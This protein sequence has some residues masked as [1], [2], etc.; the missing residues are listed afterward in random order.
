MQTQ[1]FLHFFLRDLDKLVAEIEA[2]PTEESL[3]LIGGD[4]KNAAGTL[5]LHLAGNLQHFFGAILGGTGYE[6]QRDLEF[7]ARNVPKQEILAGL[8]TARKVVEQVLGNMTDA[9]LND[10]FPSAHFGENR[11]TLHALLHLL[12][13]LSY[14]L[15][16][17]NYLRRLVAA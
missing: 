15:G 12:S 1:T 2:F 4:V 11:S 9:Q 6:R 14:H 16:Q 5:G 8:Q 7:S 13:H 3:W 17:V 10:T